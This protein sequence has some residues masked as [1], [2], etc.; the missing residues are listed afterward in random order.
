MK[1]AMLIFALFVCIMMTG[2]EC[3]HDWI[4]TERIVPGCVT[5]GSVSFACE[6]CD[7]S[8]KEVIDAIGHSTDD[9]LCKHCGLV[10]TKYGTLDKNEALVLS[11]LIE[12]CTEFKNPASIRVIDV[13]AIGTDNKSCT[14]I[15]SAENGF[16]ATAKETIW[17]S[18]DGEMLDVGFLGDDAFIEDNIEYDIASIN[19]ALQNY[20]KSMGWT[21]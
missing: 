5:A 19:Q 2:C 7:E 9:G 16:G 15:I 10:V 1:K 4:E 17:I 13:L 18:D 14:V 3:K 11:K 8:Y 12:V 20:Y 6:K 21:N